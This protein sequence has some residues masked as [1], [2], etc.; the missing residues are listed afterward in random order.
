MVTV[1]KTTV[2]VTTMVV[3]STK[4]RTLVV[5]TEVIEA[6]A[7]MVA[8]EDVEVTVVAE[9]TVAVAMVVTAVATVVAMINPPDSNTKIEVMTAAWEAGEQAV[10]ATAT[11]TTTT[12]M[13]VVTVPS[14]A[15]N[16]NSN[17]TLVTE[18]SVVVIVAVI[19]EVIVE[20]IAV[21]IKIALLISPV[22]VAN[23]RCTSK[24]ATIT[25]QEHHN[26]LPAQF[27]SPTYLKTSTRRICLTFSR[28]ST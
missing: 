16:L 21:V 25:N 26:K 10:A 23:S 2:V 24:R 8:E 9:E 1:T 13:K 22:V 3:V 12:I 20:V 11:A 28:S 19:V 27:S 5:D 15:T 4:T 7:T 18:D 14:Q 6:V 17:N